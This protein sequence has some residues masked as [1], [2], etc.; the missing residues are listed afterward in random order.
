MVSYDKTQELHN[1]N[2]P[3]SVEISDYQLPRGEHHLLQGDHLNTLS[4]H[5]PAKY[6][7]DIKKWK[8]Y[9]GGKIQIKKQT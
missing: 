1:F 3:I 7:D 5:I 4:H 9:E 8:A 2:Y 6:I